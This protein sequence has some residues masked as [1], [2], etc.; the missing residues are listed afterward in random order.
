MHDGNSERRSATVVMVCALWGE[1]PV[2]QAT[3]AEMD[4]HPVLPHSPSPS[5]SATMSTMRPSMALRCPVN[6]ANSSNNTSRRSLPLS[7]SDTKGVAVV[8]M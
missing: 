5:I 6:S 8:D 3:S 2:R 7:G 1:I 4:R